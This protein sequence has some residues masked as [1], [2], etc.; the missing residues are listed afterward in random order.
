MDEAI[1]QYKERLLPSFIH[2]PFIFLLAGV[3][4]IVRE[5]NML[6]ASNQ[7]MDLPLEPAFV[8]R[9]FSQIRILILTGI[10]KKNAAMLAAPQEALIGLEKGSKVSY[11]VALH[12]DAKSPELF[13]TPWSKLADGAL[14]G[15]LRPIYVGDGFAAKNTTRKIYRRISEDDK[16]G[17]LVATLTGHGVMQWPEKSSK[18]DV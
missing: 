15:K 2:L 7:P 4:E 1:R 10:Q 8:V 11:R 18:P 13:S 5:A 6:A 14:Y 3:Q 12:E 17:I 16:V 9:T